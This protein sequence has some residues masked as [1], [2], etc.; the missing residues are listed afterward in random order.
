MAEEKANG[1]AG[2]RHADGR[3]NKAAC[4][5]QK[6]AEDVSLAAGPGSHINLFSPC[7][8]C[9]KADELVQIRGLDHFPV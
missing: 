3:L 8:R 4:K 2:V 6:P 7:D 9:A 5:R 1:K